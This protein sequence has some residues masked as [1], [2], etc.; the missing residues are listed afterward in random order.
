MK[1]I[2]RYG[3]IVVFVIAG[4][5][6]VAGCGGDDDKGTGTSGLSSE[7]QLNDLNQYVN[8]DLDSTGEFFDIQDLILLQPMTQFWDGIDS[9]DFDLFTQSLSASLA[10]S[11][12]TDADTSL[13]ISYDPIGGW[14][15]VDFLLTQAIPELGFYTSFA[16]KDSIRFETSDG[17]VPTVLN[18]TTIDRVL[19]RASLTIGIGFGSSG[20]SLQFDVQA[21]S[22]LD[23]SGLTTATVGITGDGNYAIGISADNDQGSADLNIGMESNWSDVSIEDPTS[24]NPCPTSGDIDG[25]FTLDIDAQDNTGHYQASGTWDLGI[26]FTGGGNTT[27][28]VQSGDFQKSYT[29]NICSK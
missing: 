20:N 13:T 27:I 11:A 28:N 23:A 22:N 12:S 8:F 26:A 29:G 3:I 4:V 19:Q 10:A 15:Y 5:M 9:T 16:V 7:D 1:Q 21:G 6:L 14:W 2:V 24:D 18:E 25:S 17:T